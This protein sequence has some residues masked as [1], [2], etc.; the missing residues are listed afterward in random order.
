MRMKKHAHTLTLRE[1]AN[2]VGL[3]TAGYHALRKAVD[4]GLLGPHV[5]SY[6]HRFYWDEEAV[7]VAEL[8]AI[9][10]LRLHYPVSTAADLILRSDAADRALAIRSVCSGERW[11]FE[12][13][14]LAA[15]TEIIAN[16]RPWDR[17]RLGLPGRDAATGE[18]EMAAP[19]LAR[20]IIDL[21]QA[22]AFIA[23]AIEQF[24]KKVA[25]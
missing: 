9:L 15:T 11:A 22:W 20:V 21:R 4:L 2:L 10:H 23:P 7:Y 16:F 3:T 14:T 17:L 24:R 1:I 25:R 13:Q 18:L 8:F 6:A 19:P 12:L 5:E